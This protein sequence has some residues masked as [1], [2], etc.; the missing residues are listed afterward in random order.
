MFDASFGPYTLSA[1][2]REEKEN[3]RPVTVWV[4]KR[5]GYP[6]VDLTHFETIILWCLAKWPGAV[7]HRDAIFEVMY[8]DR[9]PPS[10]NGIEVLIRRIRRKLD[11]TGSEGL[12][13]TIRGRGYQLRNDWPQATQE[14]AA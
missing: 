2:Q 7:V 11:P 9:V 1:E 12:I 3:S 13:K 10:S 5:D 14:Q 4:V 6:P 8:T